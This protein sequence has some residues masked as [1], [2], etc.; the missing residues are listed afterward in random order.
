MRVA[1]AK[2][3]AFGLVVGLSALAWQGTAHAASGGGVEEPYLK[4]MG[5]WA[6][7]DRDRELKRRKL[8][9]GVIGAGWVA[10]ENWNLEIDLQSL[11]LNPKPGGSR[12][13]LNSLSLNAMNVHFR[14]NWVS[15]Y[16]LVGAGI[17]NT[18][19]SGERDRDNL[20]LQGG[21]GLLTDI[22]DR[23]ALR[24]EVLYRW[25]N[26]S[27]GFSD[28]LVNV[29]FQVGIGSRTPAPVVAQEPPPPP[30][31]PAPPPPPPPPPEPEPEPVPDVIEL[32]NVR[33]E[34]N[35]AR[36]A[37]TGRE[38]LIGAAELL[39]RNPSV[40]VEPQGHTDNTGPVAFNQR[41]SQE[42]AEAVRQFLIEQGVP[43]AQLAPARGYGIDRPIAD[44]A[45]AEG[46]ARNRRV[47]LAVIAR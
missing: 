27:G 6:L 16:I 29:G 7:P 9:G 10:S 38:A 31:P 2:S 4:F 17:L 33:F 28:V 18:N 45:T 46:R 39:R 8:P 26:A 19:I 14:D 41:L 42:R 35:S 13:R 23:I 30:P 36:L 1:S 40:V 3:V 5:T 22:T 43:L 44:N 12:Q 11:A 20:Q 15:P 34:T 25:E 21:V 24:S 37:A 32:P 47:E